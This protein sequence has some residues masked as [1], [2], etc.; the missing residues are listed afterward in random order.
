MEDNII[1][2]VGAVIFLAVRYFISQSKSKSTTPK[3][4]PAKTVQKQTAQPKAK[5]S[6][7]DIFSDFVKE[8]EKK[9]TPTSVQ[10]KKVQP[11]PIVK[12]Q[13][14]LDWQQVGIKKAKEKK[15]DVYH[16]ASHKIDSSHKS[17]AAAEVTEEEQIDF[18]AN[19]LDWTQAIITKEILTRK[20]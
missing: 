4:A 3:K 6:I 13:A 12:K 8:L 20:F 7:D 5:Q 18:D 1:Y 9:Q 11:K 15:Q 19:G 2:I 17:M 14:A 10:Q 16:E